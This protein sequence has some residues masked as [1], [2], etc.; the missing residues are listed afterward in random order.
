M[1]AAGFLWADVL[2]LACC[3]TIVF[4]FRRL[5]WPHGG[6]G[7]DSTHDAYGLYDDD[8]GADGGDLESSPVGAELNGA[9][10]TSGPKRAGLR[11]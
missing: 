11:V 3:F 4:A 6:R 5:A 2:A 1:D 9:F 7:G 8:G 10:L